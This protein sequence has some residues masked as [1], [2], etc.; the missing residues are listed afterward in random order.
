LKRMFLHAFK[1]VLKHP[2]TGEE[3]SLEAPLPEYLERFIRH[4]DAE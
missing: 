4:L 2:L 3:L 1:M